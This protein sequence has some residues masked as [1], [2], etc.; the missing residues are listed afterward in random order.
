MKPRWGDPDRREHETVRV[1]LKCGMTKVTRHEWDGR[2]PIHWSE[3]FDVER[4]I[5]TTNVPPCVPVREAAHA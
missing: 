4:P 1:C 2:C 5:R 3:Y